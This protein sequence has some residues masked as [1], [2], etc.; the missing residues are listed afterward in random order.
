M[1]SD[2]LLLLEMHF[3][4]HLN[5]KTNRNKWVFDKLDFLFGLLLIGLQQIFRN[6]DTK[7]LKC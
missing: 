1:F 5:D 7:F 2:V 6:D 3:S 4:M